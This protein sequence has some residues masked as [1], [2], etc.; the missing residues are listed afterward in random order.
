MDEEGIR[1]V[2]LV[3]GALLYY[4]RAD[5]N[6]TLTALSAIGSLQCKATENIKKAV[7]MLL[8]YCATH[9][10]NEIKYRSCD[11]VLYGHSY[12]GFNNKS[13]PRRRVGAYIY[14]SEDDNFPRWNGPVLA[15]A[16]IMKY[17]FTNQTIVS[18]KIKP[19][20]LRLKWL[21]C[22]SAQDQFRIYWDSGKNN[23]GD[24]HT[25]YHPPCYHE[26]KRDMGFA[27]LCGCWAVFLE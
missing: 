20:D 13:G 4:G 9:A 27:G 26:S 14:L 19:S 18:K 24:Y 5:D 12:A 16:Q 22:R 2:Q 15:I 3:V 25:K 10:N 21:R 11:M 1:W 7:N 6:K 17:I 23:Y 8:E